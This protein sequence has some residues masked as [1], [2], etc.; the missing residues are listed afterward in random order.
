MGCQIETGSF[1]LAWEIFT[2]HAV[3][4]TITEMIDVCYTEQFYSIQNS[5][6][7]MFVSSNLRK[8]MQAAKLLNYLSNKQRRLFRI[9]FCVQAYVDKKCLVNFY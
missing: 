2:E 6:T 8:I 1:P 4:W 3:I 9:Q 7:K 5:N